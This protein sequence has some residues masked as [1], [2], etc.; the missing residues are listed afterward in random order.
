MTRMRVANGTKE[1]LEMLAKHCDNAII[2]K[3]NNIWYALYCTS[4]PIDTEKYFGIYL[5]K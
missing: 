4:M 3:F 1:S 2:R 5:R